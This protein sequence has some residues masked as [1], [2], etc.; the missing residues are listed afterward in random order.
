M[1]R[2]RADAVVAKVA[3]ALSSGTFEMAGSYRRGKS[4]VGDIDI[5]SKESARA[6]N[7]RLRPIAEEM[8]NEGEQKTSIRVLGERVDIRFTDP[9]S[10]G[11]MLIYLT[12]SKDFNIRLRAIAI[13]RGLKLNEYGLEE[14]SGGTLHT[15]PDEASLLSFLGLPFIPPEIREDRGEVERALAGDLPPLV[16]TGAIRGDLHVHTSATDGRMTL[17]EARRSRGRARV[18]VHPRL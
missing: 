16:E 10:F 12:G 4:T 18:P 1:T 5:V 17:E 2:D 6:V 14:R 8:I 7:P 15:F 3:Q 13:D 9:G 11:S